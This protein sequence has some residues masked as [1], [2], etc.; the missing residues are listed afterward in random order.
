MTPATAGTEGCFA[1]RRDA[2]RRLAAVLQHLR[3]ADPV[4][5]ALPRSG[6]PVAYEVARA[7]DAPLDVLLVR[8]IGAPLNPKF[9]IG[10]VVDGP[11]PQ[12]FLDDA[13]VRLVQSPPRYIEEAVARELVEIERRRKLYGVA[14]TLISLAGRA[15][16]LVDDGI[17]TGSTARAALRAVARQIPA[18]LVLAVPVAS[19]DTLAE[20]R[21]EADEVVCLLTPEL[22]GAVGAHYA[23]FTQTS[24]EEVV[25]LLRLAWGKGVPPAPLAG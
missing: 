3:H 11:E 23:D 14:R 21:A 8:K 15:V 9:G 4:V 18:W 24:N 20:L 6:V 16:I 13:L 7:L 12:V 19:A 1:D 17:A 10:A 2:G 25:G 5:L 22:F